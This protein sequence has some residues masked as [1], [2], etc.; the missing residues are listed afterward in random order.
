MSTY[1]ITWWEIQAPDLEQAKSFYGGLFG[2]TF[3]PFT[4]GYEAAYDPEGNM[5][6]GITQT[7]GDPAG[8]HINVVFNCDLY[9]DS[10]ERTQ[11][12]VS[13]LGGKVTVDRTLIAEGMGWHSTVLDPSGLRFGLWTGQP[14]S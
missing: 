2:W 4:D 10:L 14:A 5:V 13:A 8:R 7:S 1:P 11:A 3:K 6:C 9:S 12:L